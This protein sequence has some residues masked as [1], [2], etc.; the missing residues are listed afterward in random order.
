VEEVDE[1]EEDPKTAFEVY[2]EAEREKTRQLF[3]DFTDNEVDM[4]LESRWEN[5]DPHDRKVSK[6]LQT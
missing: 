5:I 2:A 1:A 4:V 3:A 6:H